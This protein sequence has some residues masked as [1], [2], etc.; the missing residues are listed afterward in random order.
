ML[1]TQMAAQPVAALQQQANASQAAATATVP[2][3]MSSKARV[4]FD[5]GLGAVATPPAIPTTSGQPAY[6]APQAPAAAAT[7]SP[8]MAIPGATPVSSVPVNVSQPTT[9]NA[10][11]MPAAPEAHTAR[12]EGVNVVASDAGEH[13]CFQVPELQNQ[14]E[15]LT[16]QLNV[17]RQIIRSFGFDKSV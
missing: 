10:A 16:Q 12:S 11:L 13:S 7:V 8:R 2:E 9:P 5:T 3:D 4:G 15:S 6:G 14:Y 17:D 1:T